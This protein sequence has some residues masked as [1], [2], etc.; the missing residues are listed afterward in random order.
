MVLETNSKYRKIKE[1]VLRLYVTSGG[2][3]RKEIW[4]DE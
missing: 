1:V 2:V 3:K 4:A